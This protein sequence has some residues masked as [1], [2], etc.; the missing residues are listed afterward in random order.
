MK[1]TKILAAAALAALT[2]FTS[3]EEIQEQLGEAYISVSPASLEFAAV[4][5]PSQTVSLKAT[6]DWRLESKPDWVVLDKSEG[7]ASIV[8]QAVSVSVEDN[9]GYNRQ[10]DIVF[11]IGIRKAAV[12]VVQEGSAGELVAEGDGTEGNP[13]NVL[14]VIAYVDSLGADVASEVEVYV[15][16]TVSMIE[17]EFS[18]TYGNATFFITDDGAAE[19]P[20]FYVFRV[21]YINNVAWTIK[22]PQIAKGDEVVVCSKVV[23]YK[24]NTPETVN[25]GSSKPGGPYNGHLYSV[26]GSTEAR[27]TEPDFSNAPRKTVAEFIAAANEKEF[28]VLHGTVSNFSSQYCSFNLTDETGAIVVYSVANADEWRDK[29]AN[30]DVVTLAGIYALYKKDGQPD[31]HEVVSAWIMEREAAPEQTEFEDKTVAE[32]ISLADTVVA[33]RLRGTVS[34]FTTG[35]NKSG[36]PYMQFD[37][38]DAAGSTVVV[39]GFKPGQYDEWAA[40]ISNRGSVVL[41]GVYAKYVAK[42]GTVKHEV[43]ETVVESFEPAPEQTEFEDKTVAEFIELKDAEVAYRLHGTVSSFQAN[44]TQK[45]MQFDIVD[46][47]G[48]SVRVYGFKAGQYD[49]WNNAEDASHQIANGGTVV[50]HGVYGVYVS[51]GNTTH[52]VLETVIESFEPAPE[53]SEVAEGDGSK[54]NPFN[55][56]AAQAFIDE[57]VVP[58]D[59]D[60]KNTQVYVK[61][62]ICKIEKAFTASNDAVFWI[63]S[64]GSAAAA[65]FEAYYVKYLGNKAWLEGQRPLAL[66]DDVVIYGKLKKYNSTYENNSGA[67]IYSINGKTED[68]S[69]MFGVESQALSV[70]ASAT[71]ATVKVTGNVAWTASCSENCE[72]SPAEGNGAGD[73]TVTF[74]ANEDEENAKTYTVTVTTEAEVKTKSFEVVITQNKKPAGGAEPE[75]VVFDFTAQGYANAQ[76]VASLKVGDVTVAFNKGSNSNSPKYYTTGTGVRVYGGSTITVSVDGKTIQKIQFTFGSGDSGDASKPINADSG[77]YSSGAWTGEASSVVLTVDG[78]SGHRRISKMVVTVQ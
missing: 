30:K 5:A 35:V 34:A 17:E 70:A 37:L 10:G 1:F 46:E 33:Y 11:S 7:S 77:R 40:K 9:E 66:G 62:K 25:L 26:N 44:E 43:M 49:I 14:G 53:V 59:G 20:K 27:E 2:F 18:F 58:E 23:N 19:S 76:E 36:V 61:G 3:C 72:I 60:G 50:L 75:D 51:N 13:F 21:K 16:G 74:V 28:Y 12:H 57:H 42:D 38:T 64:D 15:K 68:D 78:T 31:K 47:S 63:S 39:Y 41:H 55:V 69:P 56:L 52:E 8:E 22:N 24:G 54:E 4:D 32:F 48:A 67:Y 45:K 29:L 6:R 73:I 71:S 65:Q